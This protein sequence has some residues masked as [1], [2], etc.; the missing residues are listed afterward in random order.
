M[1]GLCPPVPDMGTCTTVFPGKG[2]VQGITGSYRGGIM[3]SR[4]G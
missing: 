1:V 3:V 4:R 2:E